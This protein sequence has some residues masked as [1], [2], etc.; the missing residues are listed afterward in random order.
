MIL[1]SFKNKLTLSHS[2]SLAKDIFNSDVSVGKSQD[3]G[4]KNEI[5]VRWQGLVFSSGGYLIYLRSMLSSTELASAL[6]LS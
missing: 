1:Y 5:N 3:G 6:I 2:N 4:H